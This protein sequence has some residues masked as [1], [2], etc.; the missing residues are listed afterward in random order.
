MG[1]KS[2]NNQ[3]NGDDSELAMALAE[4]NGEQDT[5]GG[6]LPQVQVQ[7]TMGAQPLDT[8]T[9][10]EPNLH[11]M[12]INPPNHLADET[13]DAVAAQALDVLNSDAPVAMPEQVVQ[14]G[15]IEN[16]AMPSEVAPAP[17]EVSSLSLSVD[18]NLDD[19]NR[20]LEEVKAHALTELRPLIERLGLSPSD[21]FDIFLLTIRS[22]RDR[23][24]VE[25][26]YDAARQ[27]EDEDKRARALLD[28]IKEIDALEQQA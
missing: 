26:A 20:D 28:I 7:P 16:V 18:V 24:L 3:A 22:T 21:K 4:L 14:E 11:G 27:I 25:P 2:D 15:A 6:E 23:T 1:G 9:Q 10:V 19:A 5:S 17:A 13:A 12:T 8:D